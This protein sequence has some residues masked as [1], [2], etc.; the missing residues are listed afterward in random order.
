VK[1]LRRAAADAALALA[2]IQASPEMNGTACRLRLSGRI[3]ID[4]SPHV[5]TLLLERLA[6]VGC[7]DLTVDLMDVTYIDCSGLAILVEALRAARAHQKSFRLSGLQD[8]PRYV[9]E[10]TR[11]LH[12]FEE[13]TFNSEARDHV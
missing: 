8:R 9:L 4:S 3:T 10:A 7:L 5:R 13:G 6:C 2:E 11:L 1:S 12:L